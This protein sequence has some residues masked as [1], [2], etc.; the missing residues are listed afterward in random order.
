MKIVKYILGCYGLAIAFSVQAQIPSSYEVA[1][2]YQFKT[3]AVS[4]TFDDNT[5]NQLPKALPLFNTYGFKTT[6]FLVTGWGPNWNSYKTAHANGHEIASHTVSH[7]TSIATVSNQE[8]ELK[9]SQAAIK[10]NVPGSKSETI[11][12]P[13]C[14]TGNISL[15]SKYY[16]AGRVCSNSIIPSSPSDFYNLSSIIAGS[17][18]SAKT[19]ADF[20]SRVTSAKS[21]KGWAVFLI[22]GVDNDGGFSPI[23]STEISS[24]LSTM[25]TT[26]TDVWVGTFAHVVKYIKERN[27]LSL[28]EVTVNA[29]SLQVTPTDNLDNAIYTVPV[30]VRRLLPANWTT[31]RVRDAS[32]KIVTS[33][34]VTVSNKKYVMFDVVPDQGKI[35]I[36]NPNRV[37]TDLADEQASLKSVLISPNPFLESMTVEMK[38]EFDYVVYSLEGERLESGHAHDKTTLGRQLLSGVYILE[39]K[40]TWL[41]KTQRIVKY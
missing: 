28:A 4:Y 2:W 1:T 33:S 41:V 31:A 40:G 8:A 15:I 19:A 36:A 23:A 9:D 27:A 25:N 20:N 17:Q 32:G 12:Y 26:H 30:T 3:A 11:A 18:G 16:I 24:H 14:N 21:S 29:D 34:I 37:V 6:F 22:H 13:N 38:G 39:V 7:P 10:N 35:S 5:S